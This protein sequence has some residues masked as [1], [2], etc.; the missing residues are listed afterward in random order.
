MAAC[1]A[2]VSLARGAA[3][4]PAT[5]DLEI[6]A[7]A[8][9]APIETGYFHFGSARGPAGTLSL[10]NR[11]LTLNGDPFLPVMGEFHYSRFPH[12]YWDEELAK[13]RAAGVDIVATYVLWNHHEEHAGKFDWSEDRNLREFVQ[14]CARHELKVFVR[15]GPWDHAEAR[16]GGVPDWVVQSTVTRRNDPT[17]LKYVA[18]L[19]DQIGLQLHGLLWKEGGPVIGV[20]LENEYNLTGPGQGRDHIAALKR[21]A[22]SAGL[23]VPYYTVTGW[24]GT[25]YPQHEVTPVFGGYPDEPWDTSATR[26]SP[27]EPYLFRFQSRVSGNLGAQ[28]QSSAR[29]DAETDLE[30]TPFLG[31]EFGGGVPIMYRRRPTLI[32]DDVGAMLPVQLG[33][34]VNLYG[35][36]MFHGGSN[37]QAGTTLEENA[38]LGGYNDVPIKNY[39]FQAPLD[40]YGSANPVLGKIRPTLYFLNDFGSRLAPMHVSA[41]A[42]VPKAA[43]DL[44]TARLSVRSDGDRGFLFFNNY[45]RQYA[46]AEQKQVRFLIHLPGMELRFPHAPIDIRSGVYFIWPFNLDMHGVRLRYATAQPMAVVGNASDPIYVFVATDNLS[47]EFSFDSKSVIRASAPSAKSTLDS[48]SGSLIVSG[49]DPQADTLLELTLASGKLQKVLILSASRAA[50]SWL[51]RA[52]STTTLL[53]SRAQIFTGGSA[54]ILRSMADP[55]FHFDVYPA[56]S[57][58]MRGSLTLSTQPSDGIFARFSATTLPRAIKV[59]TEFLHSAQPAPPVNIGGTAKAAVQPYPETFASSAAWSLSIEKGALTGL[60]DAFLA[61]RYRGDIARLFANGELI[62]DQFYY[63]PEW[64]IGLKRFADRIKAPL[65][66]TVLP[67]RSDAPIYIEGKSTLTFTDGQT[68]ALEDVHVIP[69]YELRIPLESLQ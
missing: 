28:T 41:P 69:E 10:N 36:Y 12:Q 34:G 6:D 57:A 60:S 26:L 42:S 59:S 20:Q 65:T 1:L 54:A 22:L 14:L 63:G 32:A 62:D 58:P 44:Q 61:I 52:K 53:I 3:P 30:H 49:I 16:F 27:R 24:D 43:D 67:L 33:S 23:D 31:A 21:L 13:M 29:G 5:L 64:H 2:W 51:I 11:Y 9:P 25:T 40:Q 8:A 68:A 50:Q 35:F 18:R 45:V 55:E 39:D 47:P 66:L 48:A 56:P 15:L 38:L 4:Q 37:P 17:Y 7:R 19:Y 46:M